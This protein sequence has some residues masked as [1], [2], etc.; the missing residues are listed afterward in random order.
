M[1][2]TQIVR[3]ILLTGQL[4]GQLPLGRLYTWLKLAMQQ[5]A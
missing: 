2:D 1:V 4:L 5:V 3:R